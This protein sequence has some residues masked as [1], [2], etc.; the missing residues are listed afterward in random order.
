MLRTK[1]AIVGTATLL[2][3]MGI[4][5]APPAAAASL[6]E[7]PNFG[8]NPGNLRMHVYV[9]NAVRPTPAIVVAMHPCGGNGPQFYQSS[10]FGRLADQHGFVV[11]YPSASNKKFNCFDN[12]SDASKIRGAGTDVESIISMI[13]YAKRQ[14]QGDPN[15]VYATG[16]SSG[17]MMTN[18]IAALYPD[19]IKAGAA[20]MGVPFACFPNEAAYQPGGNPAPCAGNLGKTPQQWGDIVRRANPSYTGPWPRM[21][22]WH[23]TADNVVAYSELQEEIDQWTNVHGLGTTPTSTDKPQASWTRQRWNDSSST[24]RVEAITVAGAGHNLPM[25]GMAQYAIQF[26]GLTGTTPPPPPPPDPATGCR[27]TYQPESWSTGF[28]ADVRITNTGTSSVNGWTLQWTWPG[29]QQV[30][31]A[32]NATVTQ[33]G[34]QANARN[35]TW[36]GTIAPNATVSFGFQ[37]S[38]SG[39]NTAPS[40]FTLNGSAC[41]AG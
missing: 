28:T 1:A 21:Q 35:V 8:S 18:A 11:I 10:E 6:T 30:T 5:F 23:G 26:F 16:S 7:V 32:W 29:N 2:A 12:W 24:T 27:V 19:V 38:H 39:T 25:S 15:R 22:L 13:M 36:N 4:A 40:A 33:S 9:P 31:S 20:F 41:A 3:A 34:T 14:Y 37:A 17:A